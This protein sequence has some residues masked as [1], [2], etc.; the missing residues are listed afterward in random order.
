MDEFSKLLLLLLSLI[1]FSSLEILILISFLGK[2]FYFYPSYFF[3]LELNYLKMLIHPKILQLNH[4]W[5]TFNSILISEIIFNAFNT[6]K[7]STF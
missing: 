6:K 2:Y 3:L 7:M 5:G 1:L 4:H